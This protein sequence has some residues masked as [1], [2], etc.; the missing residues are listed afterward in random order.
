MN[1]DFYLSP[2]NPVSKKNLLKFVAEVNGAK[3]L[4]DVVPSTFAVGD[5]Q[6]PWGNDIVNNIRVSTVTAQCK[7]GLNILRVYPVTPSFVLE[8]IVIHAES[9][10]MPYSYLGAPET[11]RTPK[12]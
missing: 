10:P 2:L 11:Y 9:K 7:A 6:Q 5:D 1:F 4:K 8:K 12:N 3:I